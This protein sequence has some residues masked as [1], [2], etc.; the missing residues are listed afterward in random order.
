MIKLTNEIFAGEEFVK[1]IKKINESND[2]SPKEAYQFRNIY[3]K[4]IE[5]ST[6]YDAIRQ[7]LLDEHGT[8]ND[9]KTQYSFKNDALKNFQDGVKS[10]V[11]IEFEVDIEPMLF[12]VELK[13]S[14]AEMDI[15]DDFFDYS[16]LA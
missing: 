5:K 9:E 12:P 8:L 7:K 6:D 13:L 2:M 11:S 15:V 10:L 1:T 14:P 3:K 4:L 16:S